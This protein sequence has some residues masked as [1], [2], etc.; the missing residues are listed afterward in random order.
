MLANIG[1]DFIENLKYFQKLG[2][3]S[4]EIININDIGEL[5]TP[6]PFKE[7]NGVHSAY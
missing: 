5:P 2:E 4:K 1:T 7:E 3:G 6:N